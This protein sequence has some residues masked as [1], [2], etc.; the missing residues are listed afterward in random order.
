M[1]AKARDEMKREYFEWLI[2]FIGCRNHRELLYFLF[3]VDFSYNISMD[4]NRYEDGINLRY[5]FADELGYHYRFV[6]PWIDDVPC[7]MLEMMVALALRIEEHITSDP[8]AGDQTSRWFKVML[9]SSGLYALKDDN[10]DEQEA[11][12]IIKNVLNHRYARNG[13]GGLFKIK[14]AKRDLRR[15]EIWYQAMW[16]LDETLE[17]S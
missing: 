10:Y 7:S 15:A 1:N 9:K 13:D 12:E 2:H 11:H 17:I 3:S 5:R 16:Y 6:T 8:E 4:G 14:N